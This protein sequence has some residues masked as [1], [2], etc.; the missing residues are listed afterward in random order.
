V[1]QEKHKVLNRCIIL[2]SG[3]SISEGL[4]LGLSDYLK[5]EVTFSINDNVKFFDSTAYTFGDWCAYRDRFNLYKEKKLVIG[6]Y[7]M[8]IGRHIEGATPCPIHNDLILLQGSGKY[9]GN[10]GLSKGL[11][12]AVLTGAFTL[13]LALR[14]GFKQIFLLGFDCC[15]INGRTHFYQGI[16]GAGQYNDYEGKPTSG[17]GKNYSGNY[18]TSFYNQGDVQLNLLW[19]PFATE[20]AM[21]YNVSLESRIL[22]FPKIGYHSMFKI[23]KENPINIKQEEVQKEIHNFLQP[24]NKADK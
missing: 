6:C 13:N 16:D 21:I 1:E 11:Y 3:S 23:L 4:K 2:A 17:V 22:V 24:Y 14:L 7:D 10:E 20:S 19:E 8:H 15:E 12:S 9:Y 5:N 18:K